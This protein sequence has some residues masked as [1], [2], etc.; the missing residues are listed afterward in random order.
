[1]DPKRVF[2]IVDRYRSQHQ[3]LAGLRSDGDRVVLR[4]G[5]VVG[6]VGATPRVEPHLRT[7]AGACVWVDV[8]TDASDAVDVVRRAGDREGTVSVVDG[9]FC[10][11]RR[12]GG[13]DRL[14]S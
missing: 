13:V 6:L 11:E 12:W 1:M 14:A 8:A 2:L 5:V 7:A 10:I 4:R 9:W 3:I